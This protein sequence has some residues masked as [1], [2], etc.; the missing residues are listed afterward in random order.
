MQ[1]DNGKNFIINGTYT[2]TERTN[3]QQLIPLKTD[4][5]TDLLLPSKQK[6]TVNY[7]PQT[8]VKPTSSNLVISNENPWKKLNNVRYKLDGEE[9]INENNP[10]RYQHGYAQH[11]TFV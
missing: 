8:L 6:L 9:E 7:I 4:E 10:S 1:T 2:D 5:T 11:I 3:Q